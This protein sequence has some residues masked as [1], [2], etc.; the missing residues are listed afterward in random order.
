MADPIAFITQKQQECPEFASFW[1]NTKKYIN[2]K[3]WFQLTKEIGT[4]FNSAEFKAAQS[5]VSYYDIYTNIIEP[6]AKSI[7]AY[8]FVEYAIVV[9]ES[10]TN[11]QQLAILEKVDALLTEFQSAT[12]TA[13]LTV[14]VTAQYLDATLLL[15]SV[16]AYY[17]VVNK[18][19]LVGAVELITQVQTQID[20]ITT[21]VLHNFT[22]YT[23]HKTYALIEHQR[24]NYVREFS[25]KLLMLSYLPAH[26][27]NTMS[28]D[29]KQ[30][31]ATEISLSALYS[32]SI[33][34]FGEVLTHYTIQQYTPDYLKQFLVLFQKGDLTSFK[35]YFA[36]LQ[37]N[38][39]NTTNDFEKTTMQ[40]I[41]AKYA[42]LYRKL[43]I[44]ALINFVF[45]K[46]SIDRNISYTQLYAVLQ[47]EDSKKKWWN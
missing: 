45:S 31:L 14:D 39:A 13:N 47:L 44:I 27:A 12:N 22:H 46:A 17:I 7:D 2:T 33:Y 43:Q 6:L 26:I 11:N 36:Q 40:Q 35:T 9:S 15:H 41:V 23:Y 3:L 21:M 19:D 42:F 8:H 1:N 4:L 25:H 16:I 29:E 24:N 10:L 30:R 5:K 32:P 18:N 20:T 28:T 34:N 37:N 38:I